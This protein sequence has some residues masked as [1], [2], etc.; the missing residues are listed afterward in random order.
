MNAQIDLLESRRFPAATVTLSGTG[1]LRISGT[2]GDDVIE[3]QHVK[4]TDA[5]LVKLHNSGDVGRQ[6]FSSD[7][8]KRIIVDAGGG[9][10]RISIGEGVDERATVL[11]GA[12]RDRIDARGYAA[13]SLNGGSGNDTLRHSIDF[14]G[15]AGTPDGDDDVSGVGTLRGMYL[16]LRGDAVVNYVSNTILQGG[17][18]DDTLY[19]AANGD[20]VD[21]GRGSDDRLLLM[22]GVIAK[23]GT[24]AV[25][26]TWIGVSGT[27][28]NYL[29][30]RV[31][32]DFK[33]NF[34]RIDSILRDDA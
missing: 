20:R 34:A 9:N 28:P 23:P 25:P 24:A 32:L 22:P 17:S 4:R 8:V 33:V 6:D 21:G 18:G 5:Y 30:Q 19:A 26:P 29:F 3:V 14:G 16:D 31:P 12:G 27:G 2:E 15:H 13:V 10:D 7:Q 11:G 1:T